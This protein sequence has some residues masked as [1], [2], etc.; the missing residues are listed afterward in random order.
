MD[1]LISSWLAENGAL[2]KYFATESHHQSSQLQKYLEVSLSLVKTY[3]SQNQEKC[4]SVNPSLFLLDFMRHVHYQ[5]PRWL[6]HYSKVQGVEPLLKQHRFC[7]LTFSLENQ[8]HSFFKQEL[9]SVNMLYTEYF[10]FAQVLIVGV[11]KWIGSF[12]N[13]NTD[14]YVTIFF[15]LYQYETPK[16]CLKRIILV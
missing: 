1:F 2:D 14:I 5:S 11:T 6:V 13:S 7:S 12:K 15:C 8:I 16:Q 10:K 3:R 4:Q 9:F